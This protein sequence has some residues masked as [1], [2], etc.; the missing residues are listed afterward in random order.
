MRSV[1]Q[2]H[3]ISQKNCIQVI[4]GCHE[5]G[6]YECIQTMASK[7][8]LT[9]TNH[10]KLDDI[11]KDL[12]QILVKASRK[13]VKFSSHP[14]SPQLHEV[15]L[16]H[17]YWQ[18]KLSQ[19]WTG[20][21]YPQAFQSIEAKVP[22]HKLYQPQIQTISAHLWL[23]QRQLQK[24]HQEAKDKQRITSMNWSQQLQPV[25]IKSKEINNWTQK[26]WGIAKLLRNGAQYNKTLTT[27]RNF[28]HPHTSTQS[29]KWNNMGI[30][31]Q[32]TRIGKPCTTTTLNPFFP[33]HQDNIYPRTTT[34]LS[35]WQMYE[36][37]CSANT[38]RCSQHCFLT[39]RQVYQRPSTKP[40]IQSPTK[41]NHPTTPQY[42][43]P[44]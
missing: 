43:S 44:D 28:T 26:G 3:Q 32:P 27:G 36:Q 31:L 11:D 20:Q 9:T 35:E 30:N 40:Q 34:D 6:I 22:H 15:Y 8:T 13:C 2:Q 7:T 33:S 24:I 23:A 17:H 14:W 16:I 18:L 21:N 5:H 42:R 19:K 29:P 1:Q 37:V 39:C 38:C 25:K 12:T 4:K 41:W 10:D